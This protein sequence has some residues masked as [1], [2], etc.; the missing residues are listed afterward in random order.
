MQYRLIYNLIIA[1]TFLIGVSQTMA[2]KVFNDLAKFQR[3]TAV[4]LLQPEVVINGKTL[5]ATIQSFS[6]EKEA[7]LRVL[8]S[9]QI[10][11]EE[12]VDLSRPVSA[13]TLNLNI[14]EGPVRILL[15]TKQDDGSWQVVSTQDAFFIPDYQNEFD[16]IVQRI[17]KTEASAPKNESRILRGAW[18]AL[19]YAEDLMERAKSAGA[20]EARDLRARLN[21]L[22]ERA[23][24]LEQGRDLIYDR[25]GYQLRGY[26]SDVNDQIQLYSFYLPKDYDSEKPWPLVIMLHGMYSNH[27]LALRRVLGESNRRGENDHAAKRSM[28]RLA[29]VPYLIVAPNA[30]ESLFYEGV[31]E[32]DVW[33]VIKEIQTLYNVD[34]DRIYLTGLSMGGYGTAKL[35]FNRPDVFAAIAPVCGLFGL[36]RDSEGKTETQRRMERLQ[37][38][39]EIA[40]NAL[41][42][43]V[44]LMHGEVDPVVPV[45]HS[46]KLNERLKELDYQSEL[47]VYPGVQHDA[48]VPAYEN[49]RIFEWFG[50]FERDPYPKQVVFKTGDPK[51]GSNYWVTIEE[52]LKIREFAQIKAVA[53]YDG[54]VVKT[55]NVERLTIHIPGHFF[56]DKNSIIITIDDERVDE[57]AF[58]GDTKDFVLRQGSWKVAE[59]TKVFHLLPSISGLYAAVNDRHVYAYGTAGS[60]EEKEIASHLARLS[61]IPTTIQDVQWPIYAEDQLSNEFLTKNHL[62]LISTLTGSNFLQK[63]I[64]RLPLKQLGDELSFCGKPINQDQAVIFAYPNPAAPGRYLQIMT[65]STEAGLHSLKRFASERRSIFQENPGDFMVL[66]ADGSIAATGLFDKQWNLETWDENHR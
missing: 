17:E 12:S 25:P 38:T 13:V 44:K 30:H 7:V 26:R 19:A 36:P 6:P 65:A 58:H 8:S 23:D 55:Q 34:P 2:E 1:A 43:P 48:W 32:Q 66:N 27:H 53:E 57:G 9:G 29:D 15:E 21:E 46:L 39:I 3:H 47:E 64:D 18:A 35:G 40:E 45:E 52:P 59:D 54:I 14:E 33:R 63:Y 5:I 28:P 16:R 22:K 49:A 11:H 56:T 51:G 41:N 37:S 20:G 31:A 62:V 4:L 50:Q 10:V 42:L 61:S 24:S 60:A